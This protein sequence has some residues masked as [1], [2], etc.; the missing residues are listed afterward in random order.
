M[1]ARHL[2]LD[3]PELGRPMHVWCYGHF[4]P[5]VVVFPTA[6]G[7]A[8]EWDSHGVIET[9][10]PLLEAG[11][12][13]LYCPESNVAAA[14]TRK[15]EPPWVRIQ[16]H[17]AY[18]RWLMQTFVP[19]VRR[20]CNHD[21]MPLGT[22]GA[23]LGATYAALFALKHPEV[24]RWALC[25]SGRYEL[26]NFTGGWDSTDVYFNNPLAFVPGLTGQALER[27]RQTHLT[28]VCGQGKWEEGC[29]EET[30][31]LAWV[32][33]DKGIPHKLDLWGHDVSHDWPWWK[34]Q[35]LF[36]LPRHVG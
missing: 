9:L 19:F 1:N 27:T 7:M 32:C 3:A 34:R 29:I 35:L 31:A 25:L 17:L 20:D 21:S 4:G 33:R 36:H 11:R 28:L 13:K 12:V 14:W 18:E 8:H 24:F 22:V 6:A 2:T 10:R 16:R 23:S 26:R 5:P 30:Q 15:E